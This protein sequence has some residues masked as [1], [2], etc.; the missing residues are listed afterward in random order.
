MLDAVYGKKLNLE[1]IADQ[2]Q[3]ELAELVQRYLESGESEFID[4]AAQLV[5][6]LAPGVSKEAAKTHPWLVLEKS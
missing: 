1:L 6:S 2:R 3:P 4:R 5:A